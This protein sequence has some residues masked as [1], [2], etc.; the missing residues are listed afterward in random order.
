MA[1]EM[2]PDLVDPG[3][4]QQSDSRLMP[5]AGVEAD[6]IIGQPFYPLDASPD[7]QA[8][9][10][11]QLLY[12]EPVHIISEKDGWAQVLSL[13]DGY[14]GWMPEQVLLRLPYQATHRVLMPL[15][16]TYMEPDIKSRSVIA[17]PMNALVSLT[18]EAT[19]DGK[20]VRMS[21]GRWALAG[22]LAPL[23]AWEDDHFMAAL[24]FM[25]TPYQWGGRTSLGL[26]CSALVQLSL[27]ACGVRAL[28]D[29]DMQ[30]MSLGKSVN[31]DELQQGDLVFFPGHVGIMAD[32]KS[33]LHAN[34]TNM[35]VT[36]DP[37]ADVLGW[38]EHET[39]KPPFSGA[40]RIL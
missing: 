7:P 20:F 14:T 34:A 12:G 39:G 5:V 33:L 40:R 21:S 18:G 37:L 25:N 1:L 36:I 24:R 9:R 16:H 38:V 27:F 26:D 8:S 23:G 2:L 17:L 10:L 19:D 31:Q 13:M 3:N 11:T 6:A 15:T 35:A 32:E 22:H 4:L 29:S 30:M 28:R